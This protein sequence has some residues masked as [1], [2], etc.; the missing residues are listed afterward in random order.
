MKDFFL[1]YEDFQHPI[2]ITLFAP[3]QV[4]DGEQESIL[5]LLN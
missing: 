3:L 1:L 5:I 4:L 2:L